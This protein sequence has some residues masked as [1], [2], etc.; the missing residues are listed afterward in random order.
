MAFI[1]LRYG[2]LYAHFLE[3]VFHKWVLDFVKSFFCIYWDDRMVFILQFVDV[4]YHTDWFVDT[5]KSLHPCDKSHLI[6]VYD[7]LMYCWIQIASSLLRIFVSVF[8]SDIGL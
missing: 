6:V 1:M 2:S 7:P 5:E 3:S 8:I 4:V